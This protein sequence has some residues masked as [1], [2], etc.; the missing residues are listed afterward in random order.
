MIFHC[1][2][3]PQL[4]DTVHEHASRIGNGKEGGECETGSGGHTNRVV[5]R[6]KVEEADR[7]GTEEDGKVGPLR[8]LAG[9]IASHCSF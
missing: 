4:E 8:G 9:W 6:D 1:H 2:P 7:D 3:F 5:G